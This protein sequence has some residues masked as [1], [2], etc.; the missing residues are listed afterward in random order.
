MEVLS[1]ILRSMRVRGSV[2]FC[3]RLDAPW[4]LEFDEPSAASFHVVRRGECWIRA[5]DSLQQLGPGDLVFVEP[6]L[7]HELL[8]EPPGAA[9]VANA[10][11]LLL[12]GY[13]EFLRD[14]GG[15]LGD[16]FPSL[17]IVRDEEVLRHPWLRTTLDQLAAE[18]L[19]QDPGS[20]LIVDKLT[21]VL[22]IE[23]VRIDFGRKQQRPLLEALDD[24]Q[25][26]PALRRLHE[27][28]AKS[29]TLEGLAGEI[30]LSR[31]AFARRFK[32]LVG[33]PMFDYLT[34]L[35]IDKAKELLS[36]SQLPIYEIAGRVG[37]ESD[38]AFTR[39]FKKV[40]GTTPT[41]YRKAPVSESAESGTP[42]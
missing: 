10:G 25:I 7:H 17:T 3:D 16:V 13:C 32:A 34:R 29:W 42:G 37:Y 15:L 27:S 6:G 12:C 18:Y 31:T 36:E 21:E 19:S 2:Y 30:G 8:S 26:G 1:D 41:R 20:E 35:R 40:V 28:P 5:D 23:M 33:R 38:L 4:T 22:L 11:T 9:P 24:R 14:R 39:T